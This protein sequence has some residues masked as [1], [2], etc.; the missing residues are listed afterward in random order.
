MPLPVLWMP[1]QLQ[2]AQLAQLAPLL[3][4][5]TLNPGEQAVAARR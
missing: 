3:M 4:L 1:W 2:L 5:A